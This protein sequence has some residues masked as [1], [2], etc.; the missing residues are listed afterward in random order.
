MQNPYG[1]VPQ[2]L[3]NSRLALRDIMADHLATKQMA[4]NL[5]LAVKKAETE[6]AMVG[7]NLE[8]ARM[9]QELD[10]AKMA[11]GQQ[12]WQ[13]SFGLQ[14]QQQEREDRE[15]TAR[16]ANDAQRLRL[17]QAEAARRNEKKSM[18]EWAAEAGASKSIIDRFFSG[19]DLN[20][21]IDR[22][23]AEHWQAQITNMY[24]ANPA[25]RVYDAQK[26]RKQA[27]E[28]L[29]KQLLNPGLLPAQRASLQ[30]QRDDH[31]EAFTFINENIGVQSMDPLKLTHMAMKTYENDPTLQTKY[32]AEEY[33][34][35]FAGAARSLNNS[36]LKNMEG[37]KSE[38]PPSNAQPGG[39]KPLS[40]FGGTAQNPPAVRQSN[41][42]VFPSNAP[43]GSTGL[44]STAK[45]RFKTS[46]ER[47]FGK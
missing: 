6:N 7:A 14:K 13:Q 46:E 47:L 39:R 41:A 15:S 25:L 33:V 27:I 11:Q 38:S 45:R 30:K 32:S 36:V 31:M 43:A 17:S 44:G 5:D 18:Y 40:T 1:A 4:A 12:N 42:M 37:L 34:K 24:N 19:A 35:V 29:N 2:A 28:T 9:G 16:M 23:T 22:A 21:K 26:D 3:E 20:K 8:R 10:L